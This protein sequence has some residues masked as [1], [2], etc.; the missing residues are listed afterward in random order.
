MCLCAV[1]EHM[2]VYW[3]TWKCTGELNAFLYFNMVLLQRLCAD[4]NT[5]L[6]FILILMFRSM[7]LGCFIFICQYFTVILNIFISF[8]I[9]FS[10]CRHDIP[11]AESHGFGECGWAW[12]YIPSPP[13]RLVTGEDAHGDHGCQ[14]LLP[15]CR[16]MIGFMGADIALWQHTATPGRR[17]TGRMWNVT[18][19]G[20]SKGY[21]KTCHSSPH[22]PW[23]NL[24]L[25]QE[26]H[27][28]NIGTEFSL[29][30][31]KWV[32]PG[33]CLPLVVL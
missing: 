16:W 11:A 28:M 12:P 31:E 23:R 25:G 5:T 24:Q 8:C 4:S 13:V 6:C 9:S 20:H 17:S 29:C 27:V 30:F 21:G 18:E 26:L 1:S 14:M 33:P 19:Q 2:S 7:T 22:P 3:D 10:L 15:W 32:L